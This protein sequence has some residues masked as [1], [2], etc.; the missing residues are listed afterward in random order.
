MHH[1]PAFDPEEL[2]RQVR[3]DHNPALAVGDRNVLPVGRGQVRGALQRPVG[4]PNGQAVRAAGRAG[5]EL[6]EQLRRQR[7]QLSH[8]RAFGNGID[9]R[10]G[11][12][13]RVAKLNLP[14]TAGRGGGGEIGQ[15]HIPAHDDIVGAEGQVA[16]GEH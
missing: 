5:G 4:P 9:H 1:D 12:A 6:H 16:H 11:A 7:R 14:R 2:H 15:R 8:G 10:A 3:I 13:G